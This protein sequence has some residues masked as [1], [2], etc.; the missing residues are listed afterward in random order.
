MVLILIIGILVPTVSGD[1]TSPEKTKLTAKAKG[2]TLYATLTTAKGEPIANKK[3]KF[4]VKGKNYYRLTN[5]KGTAS[6]KFSSYS[7]INKWKFKATFIGDKKYKTSS[8]KGIIPKPTITVY[9]QDS[10]TKK[11]WRKDKTKHTFLNYCP[12]CGRWNTLL[13]NPKRVSEG[14]ITCSRAKG[15][16]DADYCGYCGRDKKPKNLY[17]QKA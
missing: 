1:M 6:I 5:S 9:A 11:Y 13:D 8:K 16:C 17:L 12:N 15:G 7:K 14:E 2:K 3:I 10:C 4:N